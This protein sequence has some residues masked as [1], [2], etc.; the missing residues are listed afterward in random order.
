MEFTVV[1]KEVVTDP[2]SKDPRFTGQTDLSGS[3]ADVPL[4]AAD[5]H[6]KASPLWSAAHKAHTVALEKQL[7]GTRITRKDD[8]NPQITPPSPKLVAGGKQ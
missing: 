5:S 6:R 7:E 8:P 1:D 2:Y 3:A 4:R